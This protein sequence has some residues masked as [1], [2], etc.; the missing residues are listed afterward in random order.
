MAAS[1]KECI[2]VAF[3]KVQFKSHELWNQQLEVAEV[4]SEVAVH[5]IE[6]SDPYQGSRAPELMLSRKI[7]GSSAPPCLPPHGRSFI[8]LMPRAI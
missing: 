7:G 6:I 5:G 8:T 4:L 3:P 2:N 1:A